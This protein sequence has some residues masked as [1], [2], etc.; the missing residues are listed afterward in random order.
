M[1]VCGVMNYILHCSALNLASTTHNDPTFRNGNYLIAYD[2]LKIMT[3]NSSSLR[4]GS[5]QERGKRKK[6]HSHH[7]A[8]HRGS[9]TDSSHFL[10][11]LLS[12]LRTCLLYFPLFFVKLAFVVFSLWLFSVCLKAVCCISFSFTPF[13]AS[14]VRI[15]W[16]SNASH[17][18]NANDLWF[19][20][21]RTLPWDQLGLQVHSWWS[22]AFHCQ[23]HY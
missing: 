23:Q 15:I 8:N 2:I 11:S 20:L 5:S 14:V 1:P 4:T 9:P 17:A 18:G 22:E 7:H 12:I 16:S 6:P 10:L 13:L 19:F 3:H 21:P